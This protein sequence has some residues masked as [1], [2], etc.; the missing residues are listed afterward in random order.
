MKSTRPFSAPCV[1]YCLAVLALPAF[2]D[3]KL[4]ALKVGNLVY[5][6][7][8]ITSVSPTDIFFTS[9]AGMS[10]AKLK[11]L[12]P[13]L[14]K[15]F[16]YNSAA[17]TAAE[18]KQKA[19]NARYDIQLAKEAPAKASATRDAEPDSTDQAS[20][21]KIWAKSFLNQPA[22]PL[23]VE[24]WLTPEPDLRGKFVLID[25]WATWCAPCRAAIPELNSISK[26]YADK[27]I[28][29]GLTDQTEVQVRR[30]TDPKVD[31]F[32]ASDTQARTKNLVGVTGI[33]HI[34]L[35]DPQGIVRW[36]GFPFLKGNELSPTVVGG[37][38][39]RY[40]N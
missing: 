22:P 7:V 19:A 5:S 34:L 26:L 30:M 40:S 12:D 23:Y 31:Y 27:L 24:K 9:D 20:S 39:A 2:A 35:M 13:A 11:D 38:I 6:N 4:P 10:N 29:V 33:P 18:Q 28:V 15:H 36:E 17:A 32:V 3:E 14:Q 1:L 16:N 37:I 25:F 8:T 21:K